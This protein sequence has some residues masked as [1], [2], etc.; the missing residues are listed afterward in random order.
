LGVVAGL[1]KFRLPS[2]SFGRLARNKLGRN[3]NF[4]VGEFARRIGRLFGYDVMR[5]D[6]SFRFD[7]T[8]D[9]LVEHFDFDCV[10]DV[11]ANVGGFAQRCLKRLPS[12]PV[13]SFEPAPDLVAVLVEAAR[14][15]PRWH[16]APLALGDAE[17]QATLHLSRKSVFNSLNA[18]DPTFVDMIDGLRPVAHETVAVTTLDTYAAENGLSSFHDILLKVDTQGHDL[19]VLAGSRSVLSRSRAVIVELPFRNI[20]RSEGTYKE[21]LAV[22]E[23]AGF[24][25]YGISPIS[26]GKDGALLEAD[27]FFVRGERQFSR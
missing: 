2:S 17:G 3:R 13:Y 21:I 19:K 15:T 12:V 18:P 16:I 1:G 20:Y 4:A 6:K 24:A 26:V 5:F 23:A 22:M 14:K 25:V 9:R 8:L 27:A 11:G 7:A 10:I